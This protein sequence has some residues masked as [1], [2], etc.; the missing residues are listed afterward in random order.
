MTDDE[1]MEKQKPMKPGSYELGIDGRITRPCGNCGE[2]LKTV[3]W[4]YC[5][6]CGQRIDWRG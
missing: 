2:E 1:L 4:S 3:S 6:W 5:P